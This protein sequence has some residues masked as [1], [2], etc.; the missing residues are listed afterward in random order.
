M[1]FKLRSCSGSFCCSWPPLTPGGASQ[2]MRSLLFSQ[3]AHHYDLFTT[4]HTIGHATLWTQTSIPLTISWG[5]DILYCLEKSA[6]LLKIL[7]PI[8]YILLL[9]SLVSVCKLYPGWQVRILLFFKENIQVDMAK[10]TSQNHFLMRQLYQHTTLSLTHAYKDM[11]AENPTSSSL[12][13]WTAGFCWA[14]IEQLCGRGK[15]KMSFK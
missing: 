14:I 7:A 13:A 5:K 10:N 12:F 6:N 9:A 11:T 15:S 3:K 1:C 8:N 4:E 2:G